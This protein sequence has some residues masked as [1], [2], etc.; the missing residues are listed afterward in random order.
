MERTSVAWTAFMAES[1]R[2]H[3]SGKIRFEKPDGLADGKVVP[4]QR[5]RVLSEFVR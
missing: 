2:G 5:P 3:A 4:C 1:G